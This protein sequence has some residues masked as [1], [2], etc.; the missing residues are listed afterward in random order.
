MIQLC[1]WEGRIRKFPLP[2]SW[3]FFQIKHPAFP[4]LDRFMTQSVLCCLP[5]PQNRQLLYNELD[6]W[7][8]KEAS[9]IR[10]AEVGERRQV[11][12]R[13]LLH[14]ETRLLQTIDRLKITA[15][16]EGKVRILGA[17]RTIAKAG[18]GYTRFQ[19]RRFHHSTEEIK[20][21]LLT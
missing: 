2:N 12:L 14:K 4:P 20:R 6:H 21:G 17:R 16:H 9:S 11:A 10:A 3:E 15:A 13:E 7:R 1:L 5:E 8:N 18:R 19:E